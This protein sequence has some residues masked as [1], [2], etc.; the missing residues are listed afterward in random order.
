MSN[1]GE[2]GNNASQF[3]I[4]TVLCP[5]LDEHNVIFGR[6]IEG[7]EFVHMI[8]G[9]GKPKSGIVDLRLKISDCGEYV[10]EKVNK[11]EK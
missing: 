10:G 6:V 11:E 1:N 7:N 2:K 4:T 8:E 5:W 3:Y 9:Y